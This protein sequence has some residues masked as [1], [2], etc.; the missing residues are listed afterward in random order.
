M[1]WKNDPKDLP[2]NYKTAHKQLVSTEKRLLQD[3]EL[4]KAYPKVIDDY[5][6]KGY[7][8][9]V[10]ESDTK[11]KWYLPRFPV[12]NLDRKTTKV[13]VVFDA[14]VKENG[15]SMNDIMHTHLKRQ[16]DLVEV[17]LRF[18]R[19]P[20]ALACDVAQMYLHI[21]IAP[22]DQ[23]YHRFLWR[24]LNQNQV[25]DHYEFNRLVFGVNSCSF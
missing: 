21:G 19:F 18:R 20:V 4:G 15:T 17:L 25:P 1:P 9:K 24:D 2:D 11:E 8:S 22:I 6:E 16:K 10:N 12:I 3:K 5:K 7:I 13:R 23:P 14:S